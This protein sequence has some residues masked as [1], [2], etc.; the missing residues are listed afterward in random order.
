MASQESR[1]PNFDGEKYGVW[2]QGWR[3]ILFIW[4]FMCGKLLCQD[5]QFLLLFLQIFMERK[6][7]QIM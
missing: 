1:V 3:H 5:I 4:V 7:I 2:K 6:S